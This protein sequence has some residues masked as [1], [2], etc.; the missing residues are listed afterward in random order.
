M[1]WKLQVGPHRNGQDAGPAC[2][3]VGYCT[4]G[5]AILIDLDAKLWYVAELPIMHEY[6]L[7]GSAIDTKLGV[8]SSSW[9]SY[10]P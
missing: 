7:I 5:E 6:H 8:F 1:V 9:L 2:I 10:D 3:N 4:G